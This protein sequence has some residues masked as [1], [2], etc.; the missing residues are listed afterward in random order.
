MADPTLIAIAMAVTLAGQQP[1]NVHQHL[2]PKEQFN[3]QP[4]TTLKKFKTPQSNS[5]T[6]TTRKKP[7][8]KN[9]H[10]HR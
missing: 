4:P 5:H 2:I 6:P 1:N 10:P 7:R 8:S 3:Y 9:K